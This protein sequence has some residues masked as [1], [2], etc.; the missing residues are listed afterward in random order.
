MLLVG[1]SRET[2][3]SG[4]CSMGTTWICA[5][6]ML[7]APPWVMRAVMVALPTLMARAWKLALLWPSAR[8]RL[9]GT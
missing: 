6:A 4:T 2:T 1:G 5:V 9:A 7:L 8:V 3:L